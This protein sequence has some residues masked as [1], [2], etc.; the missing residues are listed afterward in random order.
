MKTFVFASLLATAVA[1][2]PTQQVRSSSTALN[3]FADKPGVLPPTG[4]FDPLGLATSEELFDFYRSVELKH[5]RVAMLAVLGYVV[6]EFYRFPYSFTLDGSVTTKT[7]GNGIAALNDIPP[8]GWVQM[9]FFIGFIEQTGILG[10]FDIVSI[11]LAIRFLFLIKFLT[12]L[13]A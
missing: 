11:S 8:I 1:F 5:G 4:Y 10:D 13:H 3:A 12:L 9:I 6:P 7:V 2:A